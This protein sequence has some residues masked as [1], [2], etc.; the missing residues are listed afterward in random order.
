MTVIS[1]EAKNLQCGCTSLRTHDLCPTELPPGFLSS[2]VP[3]LLAMVTRSRHKNLRRFL[4]TL[5][6]IFDKWY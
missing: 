5:N 3:C 2:L 4:A 1:G 6:V